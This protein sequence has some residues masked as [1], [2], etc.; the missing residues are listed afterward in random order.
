MPGVDLDLRSDPSRE[1]S[2]RELGTRCWPASTASEASRAQPAAAEGRLELV[3]KV[4]TALLPADDVGMR[5]SR[6]RECRTARSA[7]CSGQSAPGGAGSV[8]RGA[9]VCLTAQVVPSL[10]DSVTVFALPARS[11][12]VMRRVKR[13]VRRRRNA[14]R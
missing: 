1:F 9:A 5:P 6:F 7:E 2:V 11:V 3:E 10:S 12:A 4:L 13:P 14:L 8:A